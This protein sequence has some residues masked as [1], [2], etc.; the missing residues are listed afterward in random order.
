MN[1]DRRDAIKKMALAGVLFSFFPTKSIFAKTDVKIDSKYFKYSLNP[2]YPR[3]DYFSVDS[4]GK[5]KLD[6]NPLLLDENFSE[7]KFTSTSKNGSTKYFMSGNSEAAWEFVL[8]ESGFTLR[9]NFVENSVPWVIRIDQNKNHS[10]VLGVLSE[11]NKMKTP[12][13]LHLPDMGSFKIESEQE[14]INY[15]SLRKDVPVK[16]VQLSFPPAT[17]GNRVVEYRFEIA[18]IHPII[19]SIEGDARFD[20]YRRN[21]INA[22]Q[23]N[24]NVM[25]LA[26]NSSSDSCAFVQYGYSEV[27]LRAPN[28]V[29][30]LRAIDLVKMTIDSYLGGT[31][32]YGMKGYKTDNP[33][34][35][36]IDW[37]GQSSSL[38]TYPSL[39]ISGCNY[40]I[41]SKDTDWLTANYDGLVSWAEEILSRDKDGDGIIEYGFS[42]NSGSW[43]GKSNMRPAN[44]WDTVGFAH[45]D[46]YSNSLAY[47][48][49]TKFSK[50]SKENGDSSRAKRYTKFAEK[51]RSN[52]YDTFFNKKTGV[53]AGWKSEDG[54]LH[55]YYFVFV[56]AIAI[57]YGLVTKKQGNKIMDAIL[58]KM[59]EVGFDNFELGLPGNLIP[60]KRADYTHHDP[61]W[62]GSTSDELNDGWQHYENGG[63]S[64]NYVYFTLSALFKLGRKKDA[65]RIL[66]PLL[67]GLEKGIFQGECENGMTKDWRSW[68]GECWGYE[69]FLVD[70]YWSF[71]AITEEY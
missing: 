17:Q 27:A 66:F 2:N 39:L 47:R 20:A 26:N 70:N 4:L 1:T 63:T 22:L 5:S 34:T 61:R 57:A 59:D 43:S 19:S 44:W 11:E 60:I 15:T 54:E 35:E 31:K 10:T 7:I 32:G 56:N 12:C 51:L 14:I 67:K 38:D 48:A 18:A 64:G 53:L 69:G 46:A 49:L 40:F 62:G 55:D 9:S 25:Q 8:T 24:P 41:G 21:Y 71:L 29:G 3:F 52:F 42:G 68:D 58:A 50:V 65:E 6:S 36:F 28:L 37:G 45:K 16:F 23:V 30:N 13:V 33:Y